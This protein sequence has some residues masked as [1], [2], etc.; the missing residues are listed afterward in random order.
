[1]K[2]LPNVQQELAKTYLSSWTKFAPLEDLEA[3]LPAIL[4]LSAVFNA[5]HYRERISPLVDTYEEVFSA[6]P[7]YVRQVLASE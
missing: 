6:V 7:A 4:G 5:V 1:M 2:D 3:A